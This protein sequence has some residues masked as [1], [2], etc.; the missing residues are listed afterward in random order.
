[1]KAIARKLENSKLQIKKWFQFDCHII[2]IYK[3]KQKL[4]CSKKL[5][6]LEGKPIKCSLFHCCGD[7]SVG[8]LIQ[9]YK[10]YKNCFIHKFSVWRLIE[11]SLKKFLCSCMNVVWMKTKTYVELDIWCNYLNGSFLFPSDCVAA[12]QHIFFSVT[13]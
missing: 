13:L 1:M 10:N 5:N 11:F 7:F 9:K 3:K 6:M 2:I 12:W 8:S 4:I